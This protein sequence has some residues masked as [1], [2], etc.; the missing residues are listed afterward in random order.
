HYEV[1]ERFGDCTLLACR[2]ETGRTHQIRVHLASLGHALV[3]DPA[4]GRGKLKGI[5]FARQALHAWQLGL[6]H[7]STHRA[8]RWEA[9]LPA[10]FATLIADLRTRGPAA[11]V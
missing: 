7:P 9:P 4:Y 2:L 10:A 11:H 1:R 8:M 3:G 6:E 5:V